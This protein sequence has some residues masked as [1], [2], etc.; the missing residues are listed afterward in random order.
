MTLASLSNWSIQRL[1]L[2]LHIR[3]LSRWE[4]PIDLPHIP[5]TLTHEILPSRALPSKQRAKNRI[6]SIQKRFLLCLVTDRVCDVV[7]LNVGV[8]GVRISA[9]EEGGGG[10]FV[11]DYLDVEVGEVDGFVNFGG[12]F[13]D[14]LSVGE[15]EEVGAVFDGPKRHGGCLKWWRFAKWMLKEVGCR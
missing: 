1:P 10:D 4:H 6:R 5:W 3:P 8:F 2:L 14:G 9:D 15:G 13:R 12:G 11:E 7:D